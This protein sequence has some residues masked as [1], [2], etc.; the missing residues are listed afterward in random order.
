MMDLRSWAPWVAMT[1][2]IGSALFTAFS[3]W[4]PFLFTAKYFHPGVPRALAASDFNRDG[5]D[6][7]VLIDSSGVGV[8][9]GNGDGTFGPVT[10]FPTASLPHSLAVSDFDNDNIPDL[11]VPASS[12]SV[13]LG[14]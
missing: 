6:D 5:K 10:Y 11:V 13:L 2:K 8:L 7:L 3:I 12:L 14:N 9:L 4:F 1:T